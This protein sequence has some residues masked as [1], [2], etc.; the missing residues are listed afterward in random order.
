M[1]LWTEK[2]IK[3]E[4][5]AV[6]LIRVKDAAKRYNLSPFTIYH[7]SSENK[8]PSLFVRLGKILFIDL[9]ELERIAEGSRKI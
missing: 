2:T 8:F 3:L 6:Q 1:E 5:T 7:W 9:E 4:V